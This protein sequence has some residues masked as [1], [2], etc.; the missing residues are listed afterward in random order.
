MLKY[1]DDGRSKSFYCIAATLLSIKSLEKALEQ[2]KKAKTEDIKIRAK[3]LRE[4]LDKFALE[5]K[6][7]LKLRKK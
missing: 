6:V 1:F 2:A 3:R 7:E 4:I 5:E